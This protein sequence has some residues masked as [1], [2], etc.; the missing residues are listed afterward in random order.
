MR[1]ELS[2]RKLT[3][4]LFMLQGKIDLD[5]T[6][7]ETIMPFQD[8]DAFKNYSKSIDEQYDEGSVMITEADSPVETDGIGFIKAERIQFGKDN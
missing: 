6:L 3:N 5:G 1:D 8:N 4:Q 2:N 7:A